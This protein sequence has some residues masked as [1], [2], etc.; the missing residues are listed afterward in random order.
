MSGVTPPRRPGGPGGA[1]PIPSRAGGSGSSSGAGA[2]IPPKLCIPSGNVREC[3][4]IPK[5]DSLACLHLADQ[6]Q[7]ESLDGH[8]P[9]PCL[10]KDP[11]PVL[12]SAGIHVDQANEG[13]WHIPT[14]QSLPPVPVH[15]QAPTATTTPSAA[16]PTSIQPI[17]PRP[18][19]VT[20]QSS[21]PFGVK[22]SLPSLALNP[23]SRSI[24]ATPNPARPK[25]S[26][27]GFGTPSPGTPATSGSL[28]PSLDPPRPHPH[29]LRIES[30]PARRPNVLLNAPSASASSSGSS[31]LNPGRSL[32]PSLKLAI[33]GIGVGGANFTSG[34]DYPAAGLE[35]DTALV[36][37]RTP[38]V[39]VERRY[40]DEEDRN[41]TLM[42]RGRGEDD[43]ESSYGYG[44]LNNG[45][46]DTTAQM[47]AMTNDIR[48]AL[49]GRSRFDTGY[50][51]GHG[52]GHG[53][54]YYHGNG[55][56]SS[57]A[58]GSIYRTRSRASSNATSQRTSTP[59][60]G[61]RR[62]SINHSQEDDLTA[63]KN[64]SLGDGRD[65][66]RSSLEEARPNLGLYD[67]VG[68]GHGHEDE[69]SL[70]PVI[71]PSELTFIRRLG[72][73]ASG[74]VDMV[75]DKRGRIMAK[76]VC[77]VLLFVDSRHQTRSGH[78]VLPPSC[79][80]A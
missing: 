77:C 63:L 58:T 60:P 3:R 16:K 48:A 20:T 42:P 40:Q 73:G 10:W 4:H 27:S 6:G 68:S 50:G 35:D 54:G 80:S 78:T 26:L 37:F 53:H 43:G 38:T 17:L 8:P 65:S 23:L 33:P 62:S 72:E 51:Q 74:S 21:P 59:G 56:S 44:R 46:N 52:H 7:S 5:L 47:S 49:T 34:H 24:S 15:R 13:G 61:S 71:D 70:S 19:A 30:V 28:T 69:E 64:L 29:P 25:L 55:S 14:E 57:V 41:P 2:G 32:T 45:L 75:K 22:P 31:L 66:S 11:S 9:F 76:K 18:E 39:S 36:E 12:I 79:L 1:R 67:H